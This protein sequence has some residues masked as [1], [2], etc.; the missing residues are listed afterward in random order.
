MFAGFNRFWAWR[1]VDASARIE[2]KKRE[3]L[4]ADADG[5]LNVESTDKLETELHVVAAIED[6]IE[7]EENLSESRDQSLDYAPRHTYDFNKSNFMGLN[8]FSFTQ[9]KHVLCW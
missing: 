9:W 2:L 7:Q 8:H 6:E 1:K 3:H 4:L 5:E